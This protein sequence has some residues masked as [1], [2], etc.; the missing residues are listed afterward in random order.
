[1]ASSASLAAAS[2]S[3][4]ASQ[5][6]T[7]SV[8]NI[9]VTCTV[10]VKGLSPCNVRNGRHF[11]QDSEDVKQNK[12]LA[13]PVQRYIIAILLF[14][15]QILQDLQSCLLLWCC[16]I[17]QIAWKR[18]ASHHGMLAL[19]PITCYCLPHL[20]GMHL[21]TITCPCILSLTKCYHFI[22]A[23]LIVCDHF[24]IRSLGV[25]GRQALSWRHQ[26]LHS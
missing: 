20:V 10:P 17:Y 12:I 16:I 15:G 22:K 23:S 18:L 11:F 5:K 4:T 24:S 8:V 13:S 25:L 3:T 7:Q 14:I 1:M 6:Q 26:P 9:A 2:T 21:S 19:L